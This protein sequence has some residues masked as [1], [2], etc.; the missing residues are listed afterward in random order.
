L[1]LQLFKNAVAK[2]L[3]D[4]RKRRRRRRRGVGEGG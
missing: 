4:L 2:D 1:F 3:E